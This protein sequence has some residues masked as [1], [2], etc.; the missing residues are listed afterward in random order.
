M[1][2]P[3]VPH[4]LLRKYVSKVPDDV[5]RLAALAPHLP[6]EEYE[7]ILRRNPGASPSPAY[8]YYIDNREAIDGARLELVR[9]IAEAA[10]AEALARSARA[11]KAAEARKSKKSAEK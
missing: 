9:I 4:E 1:P 2:A 3:A 8:L 5:R 10:E 7:A 6:P 11:K